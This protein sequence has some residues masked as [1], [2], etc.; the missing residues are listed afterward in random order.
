[1]D[2][3]QTQDL[4]SVLLDIEADTGGR[5]DAAMDLYASDALEARRALLS[6]ASDPRTPDIVLASTG[7]S[8]GQIATRI[9]CPLTHQE[10]AGLM[11]EARHEYD[12][13]TAFTTGIH[14]DGRPS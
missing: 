6:V 12:D 3:Q 8:L 13:A 5:D 4:I 2:A 7:E 11:P 10:R 1:M 9:G 14:A